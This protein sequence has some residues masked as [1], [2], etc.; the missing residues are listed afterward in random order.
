[1][2]E[3]VGNLPRLTH[4]AVVLDYRGELQ[5][6]IALPTPS[7]HDH[8]VEPLSTTIRVLDIDVYDE[9]AWH[10]QKTSMIRF[11][12][13]KIPS[14][15]V[16][17][18]GGSGGLTHDHSQFVQHHRPWYPHLDTVRIEPLVDTDF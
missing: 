3:L 5:T 9:W 1:M 12:L 11:I 15:G 13:L 16:L 17:S 7:Q 6:D 18:V 10:S 4:L 8:P 2:M 14:L